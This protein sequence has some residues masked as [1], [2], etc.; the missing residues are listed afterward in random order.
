M[1][2][3]GDRKGASAYFYVYIIVNLTVRFKF[4]MW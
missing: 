2:S 1:R 3:L 4:K